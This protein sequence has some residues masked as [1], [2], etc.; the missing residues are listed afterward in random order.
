[1]RDGGMNRPLLYPRDS[2]A[3]AQQHFEVANLG[4]PAARAARRRLGSRHGSPAWEHPAS[5]L[6]RYDV[7]GAYTWLD[8]A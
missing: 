6:D 8:P 5:L 7:E 3:W 2:N 1:M 4:R